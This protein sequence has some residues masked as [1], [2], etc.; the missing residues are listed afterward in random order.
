[1]AAQTNG[2]SHGPTVLGIN[3]G[4]SFSSIALINK[5]GLADCIANED[6]ERQIANAISFSGEEEYYGNPARTYLVRNAANTVLGFR[7]IVGRPYADVK[8][9]KPIS[10]SAALTDVSGSPAWN[11][12][13]SEKEITL[14]AHEATV[15]FLRVLI[16]SAQDF[17][18]RKIDYVVFA[19]SP[20]LN[21]G[22][23]TAIRAAASEAGVETL[24]F[25]TEAAAAAVAYNYTVPVA[26]GAAATP[27]SA[28]VSSSLQDRNVVVLDVGAT[29][30]TATVLAARDGVYTTLATVTDNKLGGDQFDAKLIDYFSKEF[31]KKTKIAIKASNHRALT[32]L[33]LA[34]EITKRTLSASNTA[35]CS[36]E[37]L[38]EGE[39]F[40]GSINRLRFDT[41]ASATYSGI[42]DR[43]AQAI[44]QADLDPSQ[45]QDVLLV[46]GT[47]RLPSLATRLGAIFSEDVG[48][49]AQI[50]TD[51]VI[52][53]GCALQAQAIVDAFVPSESTK[54][55]EET[56]SVKVIETPQLAHPIGFQIPASSD[57]ETAVD[58]KRFVTLLD[59]HT[60]LPARRIV[61]LPL[62]TG[63]GPAHVDIA[64][65]EG[66]HELKKEQVSVEADEDD[67]E[68]EE[69]EELTT[70]F[71]RAKT[72]LA[73]L[74]VPVD[75]TPVKSGKKTSAKSKNVARLR[76]TVIIDA[77]G[78]G[79]L[80]AKQNLDD[81]QA[82]ETH[83]GA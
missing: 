20:A 13:A 54:A 18:G 69:P 2:D 41:L 8:S 70:A 31:T 73:H 80:Q 77:S 60:P 62:A 11:V 72:Q 14:T 12:L 76:L 39:D 26:A 71:V 16:G 3:F 35:N 19:D 59:A 40:H 42:V 32:K 15:K 53:K 22:Q 7:N 79:T 56:L 64:L 51:E 52:A 1:M 17:L 34:C 63:S 66:R 78:K 61:D 29:T 28:E 24:Q 83:F 10:D 43:V 47:A 65:W 49:N 37:S 6:G 81:A 68:E 4:G 74:S 48:I 57:D 38:A 5:E 25:I 67:E 36:V 58:G 23:R 50:D 21:E 45:I 82:V 55:F 33:R 30:T 44:K 46:G 27:N 75:A 9:L